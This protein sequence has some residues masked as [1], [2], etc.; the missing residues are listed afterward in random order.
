MNKHLPDKAIDLIDEACAR[1]S[2]IWTK[3]D[4]NEEYTSTE[5]KLV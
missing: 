4:R 5:E 2:S 1:Q 3:L